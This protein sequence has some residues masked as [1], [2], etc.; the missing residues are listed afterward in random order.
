LLALGLVAAACGSDDSSSGSGTTAGGGAGTTATGGAGTTAASTETPVAGGKLV[1]GIEADTGSPWTPAKI[2]CAVSCYQTLQSVLDPLV[3]VNAY[4]KGAPYLAE[5]IEPNADYTVWTIKARSGITFHDG[6]PFDGAAIADNIIRQ[7]KSFLTAKAVSDIA[8]NPDGSP[9]IV[10][11]DPMTV[12]ITMKRSWVIFPIY[13]AGQLGYIGS[14]TWLKA[15]DADPTLEPKPVGTGPFIFKDYKPGESFTA[16][17]NP[18][19][20]NKPY[21]YIDEYETRVI[22]DALTRAAALEAGD[23]DIIHTTNGDSIKKFR[24]EADQFPMLEETDYGETGYTLLHV[25]QEGSPLTDAR[26]RCAMAYATDEQAIIDKVEAGVPKIANGPFSPRQV[27]NLEDSGYPVKQDLAKA[28]ELIASYKADNPGPLNISLSTTQD[29]TNLVIAQAQQEFF[30]QAGFDDVQ[31]SQIEQ[32]KYILT[33]L[34]GN[35]Q[36]FQW[37]NHG[38]YDMDSQLIWWDSSNA[39]PVGELAINFGRIKDPVIDKALA[40]NRGATDPAVKK[41]LAETV[42]KQFATECY[43]LWGFW[44]VWGIPHTP[45]VKDVGV[46]TLPNGDAAS[47]GTGGTFAVQS[48]W[49]DPNA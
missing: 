31:I 40:D 12:Q 10:V 9:Q 2:L 16:T 11:T 33:A 48:V 34:Q 32:A 7:T 6:T 18:D 45:K 39:L 21:P 17:K 30:K 28:Q 41:E 27:G 47:P 23:V 1:V 44:T 46:F 15:A 14:P 35:F 43:N 38:G 25:T 49:I 5:S 37:R 29:A 20:W 22:P 13:L 36:A 4:G 42:N 26:V 8:T 19:Y 3:A 24:D